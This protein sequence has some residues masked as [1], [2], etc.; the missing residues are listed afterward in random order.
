MG[1]SQFRDAYRDEWLPVVH[2]LLADLHNTLQ[3]MQRRL[4]RMEHRQMTDSNTLGTEAE[5]INQLST[6][7]DAFVADVNADLEI[8]K[9][10]RDQLGPE[11]QAALDS[12]SSKL[13]AADAAV[14]ADLPPANVDAA[15]G[16]TQPVPPELEAEAD[17]TTAPDSPIA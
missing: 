1:R 9:A 14:K 12:L 10:S 7:F 6:N 11:G 8:L 4:V 13:A 15:A 3:S 2:D 5:Q 17:P 16:D